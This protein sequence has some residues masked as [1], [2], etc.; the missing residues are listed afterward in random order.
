MQTCFTA[1]SVR[2]QPVHRITSTTTQLKIYIDRSFSQWTIN[3]LNTHLLSSGQQIQEI[4]INFN[5]WHNNIYHRSIKLRHTDSQ[6]QLLR[7]R[8]RRLVA[9]RCTYS[10]PQA[11]DHNLRHVHHLLDTTRSVHTTLTSRWTPQRL[12][13]KLL[14][15]T[16]GRPSRRGSERTP[17]WRRP[18]EDTRPHST[19]KIN[20]NNSRISQT[21]ISKHLPLILTQQQT[22]NKP[23]S[24]CTRTAPIY[25]YGVTNY[26]DMV[27]WL[28]E[29]LEEEQYYCKS[30]LN[31]AVKINVNTSESNRKLIKRFQDDKTVH[32]TYQIR[33]ERAYR[34]GLRNLHHSI[35]PN[36]IQAELESLGHK[37]RNVLNIRQRV[38]K[39]PLPLY[40]ADLEPQ[41]N[42]KNIYDLQLL[43]NMKIVVEA[44]RKKNRIVQ[45][46][47]CQSYGHTKTYC[48][49]PYVWSSVVQNTIRPCA[50]KTLL[51]QPR[52]HY[53]AETTQRFTKDV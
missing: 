38:T 53:A 31:E 40:F 41:D 2:T 14:P 6:V 13:P 25:V 4:K 51:H 7:P 20:S 3:L 42:N 16:L 24:R 34:V 27:K 9:V 33:E 1:R 10:H 21:M 12:I 37:V 49:R 36:E 30:L 5:K 52:A 18:Y 26:C 44:P 43:C 11:Y 29:T 35:P 19:P 15:T 47:I 22:A 46:T 8:S 45:C 48:S 39:E 32:H 50:L 17:Q 28:T 23:H